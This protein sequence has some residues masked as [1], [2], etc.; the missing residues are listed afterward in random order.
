MLKERIKY[1][2]NSPP[3][4]YDYLM[5]L[6]DKELP[7]YLKGFFKLNTGENLN[8]RHPKTFN[9]K[10]Q[11]LK[12]Y[13]AIPIKSQLTDKVYVRDYVKSKIGE[14]YLKPVL[15]ICDSFDEID[16]DKLPD[17]FVIKCAHGCKWQN[18]IKNKNVLLANE[19]MFK[20]VKD[21]FDTWMKLSFCVL[22]GMEMHYKNIVPRIIVEPL[23][24]ENANEL[25]IEYEVY[26]FNGVP[27]I[28]QK[29][30]YSFPRRVSVYDENY[31]NLN[32]KFLPEYQLVN[33]P[34]DEYMKQAVELSRKLANDF[35][36]VRIDW[37]K[38]KD[39]LYFGEMTFTPFSGYYDFEDKKWNTILG[40]M[41]QI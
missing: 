22:G 25:P 21:K 13:D 11:W 20:I 38:Y 39:Q 10:I 23:L 37:M 6:S 19:I 18:V 24:R 15:Q 27:K 9:E 1:M 4:D 40:N 29:I 17:K 5:N 16:F 2:L 35:K 41:L 30:C 26:C 33:Y 8:L 14:K 31:K 34:A 28:Y 3:W 32:L 36:L 12:I 7:L